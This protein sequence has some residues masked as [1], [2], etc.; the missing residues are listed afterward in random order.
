M[1]GFGNYAQVTSIDEFGEYNINH[2]I[3]IQI[4]SESP[5]EKVKKKKNKTYHKKTVIWKKAM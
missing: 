2:I 5:L 4:R 1:P 3:W